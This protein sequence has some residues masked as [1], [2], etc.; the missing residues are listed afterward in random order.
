MVLRALLRRKNH[1][2]PRAR[3]HDSRKALNLLQIIDVV[4]KWRAD[5]QP[6]F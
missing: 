2:N 3:S 6:I 4:P 5:H 1:R